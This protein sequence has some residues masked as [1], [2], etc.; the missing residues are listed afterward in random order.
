M[1]AAKMAGLKHGS[2]QHEREEV[3]NGTSSEEDKLAADEAGKVFGVGR[4]QVF[5]ALRVLRE[6][7]N[8]LIEQ[9][10]M[11]LVSVSLA[12]RTVAVVYWR[13][14]RFLSRGI[15]HERIPTADT[16]TTPIPFQLA[17]AADRGLA[18][19]RADGLVCLEDER[20]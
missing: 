7:C 13:E 14:H 1:C 11:G 9:C 19:E 12:S 15:D 5:R 10:E 6:G 2:N 4:T 18:V 20:G 17:D 16:E 8:K 3:P